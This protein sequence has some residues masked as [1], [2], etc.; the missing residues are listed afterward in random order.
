MPLQSAAMFDLS[1]P[2][3]RAMNQNL[4]L[5]MMQGGFFLGPFLGGQLISRFGYDT[6]FIVLAV[7]TLA[8]AVLMLRIAPL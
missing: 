1:A 3:T 8:A 5:V 4:L 2:A 6:L 7:I